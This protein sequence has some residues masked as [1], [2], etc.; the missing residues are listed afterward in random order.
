MLWV[1]I[2]CV[3]SMLP[4]PKIIA[5]VLFF[6]NIQPMASSLLRPILEQEIICMLGAAYIRIEIL[7][8]F[9]EWGKSFVIP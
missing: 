6:P 2:D 1:L 3:F 8:L 5:S 9:S 7:H 4:V